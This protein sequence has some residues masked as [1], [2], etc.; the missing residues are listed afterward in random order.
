MNRACAGSVSC[1]RTLLW[2]NCVLRKSNLVY[3]AGIGWS[4][5]WRWKKTHLQEETKMCW[6]SHG[7][8]HAPLLCQR[9]R[10]RQ[11]LPYFY[12]K[13]VEQNSE[14]TS[15][16]KTFPALHSCC[17]GTAPSWTCPTPVLQFQTP[18]G[19]AGSWGVKDKECLTLKAEKLLPWHLNPNWPT[20]TFKYWIGMTAFHRAEQYSLYT[21]KLYATKKFHG[22]N[23]IVL[24]Q[25]VPFFDRKRTGLGIFRDYNARFPSDL[26]P[27]RQGEYLIPEERT[28]QFCAPWGFSRSTLS[29]LIPAPKA[30]ALALADNSS[31]HPSLGGLGR[32]RKLLSPTQNH[33]LQ[34]CVG[35]IPIQV[36]VF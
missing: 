5:F 36:F 14:N 6:A 29:C 12:W 33:R 2:H 19:F 18:Q 28:L 24:A 30:S 8:S 17:S 27:L 22:R 13:A 25:I 4:I 15:T 23:G 26:L 32:G 9:R 31:L 1:E 11:N 7:T 3:S 16:A 34:W 35:M 20:A 21:P 10:K